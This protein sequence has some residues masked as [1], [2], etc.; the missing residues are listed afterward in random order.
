MASGAVLTTLYFL[1]NLLMDPISLSVCPWQAFPANLNLT[2]QLIGSIRNLG[3]K[4]NVNMAPGACTIKLFTVV[5]YGF[6]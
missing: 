4:L 1:W 3:R 5:T 2:L 6:S